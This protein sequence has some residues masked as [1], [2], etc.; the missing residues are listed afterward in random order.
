MLFKRDRLKQANKQLAKESLQRIDVLLHSKR[1]QQLLRVDATL[2]EAENTLSK[3]LRK[4]EKLQ[5]DEKFGNMFYLHFRAHDEG[6]AKNR[7]E[8][9]KRLRSEL[10][11]ATGIK[12][13]DGFVERLQQ[14]KKMIAKR[15]GLLDREVIQYSKEIQRELESEANGD[16]LV[17]FSLVAFLMG[18][19]AQAAANAYQT[20]GVYDA[21]RRVNQAY[22][23]ESDTEIWWDM[24]MLG[25]SDPAAMTGMT[26]L[27]KGA[28]FEQL[29]AQETG[30]TLHSDFNHPETDITIDGIEY[31]LK[32]TDSADYVESVNRDI[33]V[34]A[35]QEV[36][37]Q[38]D[39]IDSGISNQDLSETTDR[40]L[41]GDIF[42]V[43][44]SLDT[45]FS[46]A[47]GAIGFIPVMHGLARMGQVLDEKNPKETDDLSYH[48]DSWF[49]ALVT[50]AETTLE[51]FFQSLPSVWDLF[52]N[53]IR[54]PLN[55]LHAVIKLVFRF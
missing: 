43:E 35:T 6:A 49:E 2:E 29:V 4:V 20:G 51:V 16:D 9:L 55:I 22:L 23:D 30:G 10:Q 32:A 44:D 19:G 18:L 27:V 54:I 34:I 52:L 13:I 31:Q 25:L 8:E 36:A 47:A 37:G 50:G 11:K 39:A 5:K 17:R 42:D 14:K 12:D 7:V 26:S 1:V 38:T 24:V 46:V 15:H 48:L 45:G 33:P 28:Y 40:A 53:I 3:Q 41:G 21:F